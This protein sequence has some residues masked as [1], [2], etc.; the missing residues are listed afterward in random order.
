[1]GMDPP[2]ILF[3]LFQKVSNM[4]KRILL[5]EDDPDI[6]KIVEFWLSDGGYE[7]CVAADGAESLALAKKKKPDLVILDYRMPVLNGWEV[8]QKLKA[9]QDLKNI[10]VLMMTAHAGCQAENSSQP[11][12]HDDCIVKPFQ[13]ADFLKKIKH[14]LGQ[15]ER[16]K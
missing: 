2:F 15:T 5:C 16:S 8:C 13:K 4:A 6:L 1:M 11:V 12:C 10:P 7:V 14:L 9:D 3:C